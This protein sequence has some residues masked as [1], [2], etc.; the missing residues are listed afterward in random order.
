MLCVIEGDKGGL[1]QSPGTLGLYVSA[2]TG[3]ADPD[4]TDAEV[5]NLFTKVVRNAPSFAPAWGR[6][7]IYYANAV[8]DA[9]RA[10]DPATPRLIVETRA[11]IAQTRKI[12][13]GSGKALL[14][15]ATLA[16]D[17]VKALPVLDRAVEAEP[18]AY[19][20]RTHRSFALQAIGRN[21]ASR[22]Y[23]GTGL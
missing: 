15:E 9:R 14:A 16:G 10:R 3:D 7:A 5:I 11:A 20:I 1:E 22:S 2:C 21:H 23:W 6:L 18:Q 17:P 4:F 13:P 8:E 12:D 19:Q